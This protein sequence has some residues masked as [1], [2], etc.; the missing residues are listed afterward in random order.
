M[1]ATSVSSP[2]RAS[3]KAMAYLRLGKAR[4]YHHAYGWLLAVLL[5]NLDGRIGPSTVPAVV[6]TL[7]SVLTTQWSGGAADDIGGFRDGSDARNYAGRP[8]RTVIKKPL[9]TGALTEPEAVRFAVVMWVVAVASGVGAVS[10]LGWRAP[11]A[12][13]V[14]MLVA[15]VCSV[16]YSTGLKLSYRPLGLEVTIFF[17]IGCITL[18]PYWMVA[19]SLSPEILLAAALVGVWFLLIV[20]YGNASDRVGD[21]EVSRKTLAVLLPSGPFKATLVLLFAISVTL[22]TV[23]FTATRFAPILGLVAV[24]VVALHAVQLY[25]GVVRTDWRKARFIGL[26]SVDLGC[27]GLALAFAIG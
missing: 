19:G 10:S 13:I 21:G 26:S 2:S 11:V 3:A 25:Y 12:A 7:I 9:L 4:I 24:P 1:T 17:V 18:L 8:A 14:V 16:Q 20:F 5:L 22:L 6:L 23:L 27:L 15:Q